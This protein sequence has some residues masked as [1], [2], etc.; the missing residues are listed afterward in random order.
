MKKVTI[1]IVTTKEDFSGHMKRVTTSSVAF[2]VVTISIVT[3][4]LGFL[5]LGT[6][7]GTDSSSN[8]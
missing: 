7:S 1:E 4:K 3:S 6:P 2:L 8:R 5:P